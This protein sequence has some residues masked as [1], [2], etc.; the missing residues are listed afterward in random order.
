MSVGS[1]ALLWTLISVMF[2]C[3]IL[4]EVQV[5]LSSKLKEESFE[6][7]TDF[8]QLA[9]SENFVDKTLMIKTLLE[10][11]PYNYVTCPHGFG[12]TTN[13]D[14]LRRFLQIEVNK[15]TGQRV[16]K[17]TTKNYKL[18][19]DPRLNLKIS[20]DEAFIEKHFGEYPVIVMNLR[21]VDGDSGLEIFFQLGWELQRIFKVYD[22]L[23]KFLVQKLPEDYHKLSPVR[24]RLKIFSKILNGNLTLLGVSQGLKVLSELLHLY[25]GR[26]A[27][28][29]VDA[30]DTPI[31]NGMIKRINVTGINSAVQAIFY[32]VLQGT[33]RAE[34]ALLTG[35][36]YLADPIKRSLI[37]TFRR[38]RF[39][40]GHEF[41]EYFGF[42]EKEVTKLFDKRE[43][44]EE[45]RERVKDFYDH[46][47]IYNYHRFVTLYNSYDVMHYLKYRS[48]ENYQAD[49]DVTT[50]F[51]L[52]FKYAEFRKEM[53]NI[54]LQGYISHEICY[55]LTLDGK[56]NWH[57]FIKNKTVLD[58]YFRATDFSLTFLIE[59]G[60]LIRTGE[61]IPK[62]EQSL[63]IPNIKME[64]EIKKHLKLHYYD[65]YGIDLMNNAVVDN[66]RLIVQNEKTKR[67]TLHSLTAALN[68]MMKPFLI[69]R[70]GREFILNS[71]EFHS[72]ISCLALFN[73]P[74]VFIHAEKLNFKRNYEL[75]A[76]ERI[77]E[78]DLV[79]SEEDERI[80]LVVEITFK[81]DVDETIRWAKERKDLR[82]DAKFE[83]VKY[84][85]IN[86]NDENVVEVKD[87]PNYYFRDALSTKTTSRNERKYS[88]YY[89]A[90]F[91][92]EFIP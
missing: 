45:E 53:L 78:P 86:L 67:R 25:F 16:D 24:R 59:S 61:Y 56:N 22:W 23:P 34:Y 54:V 87:A 37:R 18:F 60:Y 89:H 83:M 51:P 64:L 9:T 3:C 31:I 5:G 27:I 58:D 40:D 43:F 63:R 71:F 42:T 13:L 15:T 17:N 38:W 47:I 85:G 6:R 70:L 57:T 12:K 26:R 32:P 20:Q 75:P 55:N 33:Y 28:L 91:N 69:L 90:L 81:D 7:I 52:F 21:V 10:S 46:Y 2:Q 68:E 41:A 74:R 44:D 30:Y 4:T 77:K 72:L 79:I 65:A 8:K 29:L 36:C 92:K 35:V 14:M 66:L 88:Y 39:L 62:Y 80:A 76:E 48:F 73:F 11:Y 84:L 82:P 19:T 50:L 1:I 49:Y